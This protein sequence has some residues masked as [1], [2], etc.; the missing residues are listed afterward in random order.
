MQQAAINLDESRS[1]EP[2]A[3]S[4]AD[5]RKHFRDGVAAC[6]PVALGYVAI[7]IAFGVVARTAGLSVLEVSLMSL[8]LYA[9]SAQFVTAGLLASGA[10]AS[11][12][13]VTVF[14]VNVR[15]VLYSAALA[16]LVKH[17]PTWQNALIGTELT[18]ETFA[19]ASSRLAHS[20]EPARAP[21]L[22]GLNLT[23]Q[24]TWIASTTVGALVGRAIP[25]TRALGLDFAL[26]AMFAALLVLQ[27]RSRPRLRIAVAVALT[28]AAVAVLGAQIVPASWAVIVA[29]LVAATAGAHLEGRTAWM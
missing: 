4:G 18:D 22:F 29:A 8:L 2:A 16:P 19:V 3:R 27:V 15:H 20:Q 12:I 24:A 1:Q 21:W 25:N 28:G 13:I 7:G 6:A 17:L 5:R 14:L 11:A 23:A 10:A 9:G 26:A